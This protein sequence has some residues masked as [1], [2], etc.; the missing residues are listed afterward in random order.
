[1]TKTVSITSNMTNENGTA[2]KNQ[3]LV[4]GIGWIGFKSYNT[5][6]C[7]YDFETKKL[8]LSNDWDYSKTTTKYFKRFLN[9]IYNSAGITY[10]T[11]KQFLE[12]INENPDIIVVDNM[13]M[14]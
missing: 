13:D 8:T 5:P 6:I 10:G 4:T 9:A 2:V 3:Y 11:K 1:M 7:R 12:T 14:M